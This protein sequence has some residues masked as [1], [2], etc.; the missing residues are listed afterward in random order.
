MVS[1]H[2]L[3]RGQ[4]VGGRSEFAEIVISN[5]AGTSVT[6]GFLAGIPFVIRCLQRVLLVSTSCTQEFFRSYL[7]NYTHILCNLGDR[8]RGGQIS[9]N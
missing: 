6:Q 3:G 1:D 9:E 7:S 2:G 8:D 5:C 4:T